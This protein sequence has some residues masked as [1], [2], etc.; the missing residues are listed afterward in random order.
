MPASAPSAPITVTLSRGSLVE[1][2]HSVHAVLMNAEGKVT[3]SYGDAARMTFTRSTLKPLQALA[4]L[5]SGAAAAFALSDAEIALACASHNGEDL[6]VQA[7]AAWLARIGLSEDDLECGAQVPYIDAAATARPLANNCSGKHAGML[8]LALHM[9]FDIK[10]YTQENHPLQKMILGT[11][12]QVCG[13]D[14]TPACCGIDGCSAPNPAMPLAA[15]ARGFANF[16]QVE[17]LSFQRGTACRHLFQAMVDHP[18]HVA[19]TG[20]LD[21][22]LMQAAQGKI[23]CKIGAEGTYIAVIPEHDTV[24]ALK[25]EDGASRAGQAALYGLLQKH[26]LATEE[27]L[28]AIRST[29]LPVLKNWRGTETGVTDVVWS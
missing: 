25:T 18:M 3:A 9:G 29:A 22:L 10:G 4:L 20:R 14:I 19:G 13:E 8:T 24:I 12:A 17:S 21:T 23:I 5:E 7:V 28:D 6:H 26:T 1:S 11:I 27:T 15:L 2:R 16:M